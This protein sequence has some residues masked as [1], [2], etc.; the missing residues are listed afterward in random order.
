MLTPKDYD[1]PSKFTSFR[2]SQFPMAAMAA[3]I[4][5]YAF[6]LD[7]PTGIGKTLIGATVQRLIDD[8]VV[9]ICTTKQLQDQMINDFPY[10]KV[11]KGRSNYPCLLFPDRFP[12]IN[13]ELCIESNGGKQ[14]KLK[15]KCPYLIAKTEAENS[16]IAVLNSAYYLS[17]VN[18]VEK[19]KIRGRSTLIIDEFDTIESQLM[20]FIE[21]TITSKQLNKL[22]LDPPKFKTKFEAWKDWAVQA[23]IQV[24]N[25][26]DELDKITMSEWHMETYAEIRKKKALER[27][28]TKLN[29]FINSVDDTWVWVAG[30]DQWT[31][32]PVWVSK[33]AHYKLWQYAS[34]VVGMSATILD[35]NQISLNTGLTL[36]NRNMVY[37]KL[38]C[39]FPKENRPI[40]FRPVASVINKNKAVAWP[41][42]AK[43]IEH[44]MDEYP[45]ERILVH[46]VNNKLCSFIMQVIKSRRLITH[47][48]SDRTRVLNTFKTSSKPLVL[49]SPSMDRGVDLP[50][51][52]CRVNVIAKVPYPD[53][54][55]PQIQ[56]RV[57]G[58]SDGNHWYCHKAVSS[59][60]QM[61]G[62]VVRAEDDYGETIILD[63]KFGDLYRQKFLLFPDWF[64]AAVNGI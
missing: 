35:P 22:G 10:A 43:E 37:R 54:G 31:F 50:Y 23:R 6:L 63:E 51:D 18:Y 41:A 45:N 59:I 47:N 5:D 25:E 15:S 64:R 48:T 1:L 24:R 42:V 34:K 21:L 20:S 61:A 11:L 9:Y 49:V 2:G 44:I 29:F 52:E 36:N 58:S 16:P 8:Q 14:C 38:D 39:P 13:A 62:R 32:K 12:A 27:L 26:I 53:L 28:Y 19:S 30:K 40:N 17:E 55:D 3:G 57:Y 60:I 33:Y 46:T 56:R 4:S 7:A